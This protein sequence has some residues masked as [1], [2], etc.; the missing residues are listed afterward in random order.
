MPMPAN[1]GP[2]AEG[3]ARVAAALLAATAEY[4]DACLLTCD[5]KQAKGAAAIARGFLWFAATR[6]GPR[7]R[8][9]DILC[10][11]NVRA[12]LAAM[13]VAGKRRSTVVNHRSA[14]A[15]FGRF[16]IERGTIDADPC[17][18]IKLAKRERLPARY[19]TPDEGRAMMDA[20]RTAGIAAEV[21]LAVATGMR[22]GELIRLEWRDIDL[23]GRKLLVR[24]SKS[25][26]ARTVSLN[27][28]ACR[29]LADQHRITGG[30]RNIYPARQTWR[31]GW[32]YVDR[33]RASNWWRRSFKPIQETVT[34]F[35]EVIGSGRAYH[36]LRHTFASQ[37][38]QAG[39]SMS[40]VRDWLG[41]STIAMTEVYAHL[42]PGYHAGIEN[43]GPDAWE[44]A[45]SQPFL[46]G[47]GPPKKI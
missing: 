29:I 32:R 34:K 45:E 25:R 4:Q 47:M 28:A 19:L 18:G 6:A 3:A 1:F 9:C 26:R 39:E 44:E 20:A 16:C 14:L 43:A 30:F 27:G 22:L 42:A 36:L 31:G 33:P 46:P 23:P 2:S 35:T 5:A 13:T 10:A 17:A 11:A 37:L 8:A 15:G 21:G 41:H 38:V 12:Y 24:R 7:A 40:Q